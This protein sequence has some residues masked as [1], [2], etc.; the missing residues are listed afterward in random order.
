M[1][2][3]KIPYRIKRKHNQTEEGTKQNHQGP[4]NGN[5]NNKEITKEDNPGDRK[6]IRSHRCKN[7][8]QN[9]R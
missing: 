4:E 2:K 5:T 1:K 6:E 9:A 8:Q 3:H 7:H